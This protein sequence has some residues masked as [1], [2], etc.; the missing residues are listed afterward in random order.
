[1]SKKQ[2]EKP[3]NLPDTPFQME[4]ELDEDWALRFGYQWAGNEDD[5]ALQEIAK[6]FKKK[7]SNK[8][9]ELIRKHLQP[10]DLHWPTI[11]KKRKLS[12]EE[13]LLVIYTITNSGEDF[14]DLPTRVELVSHIFMGLQSTSLYPDLSGI[15]EWMSSQGYS[16]NMPPIPIPKR[17]IEA[18]VK[19]R[20]QD[21]QKMANKLATQL[22]KQEKRRVS[23][24]EVS[25]L[26]AGAKDCCINQ[27]TTIARIIRKEW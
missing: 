3:Q 12:P 6:S 4:G 27:H 18:T 20:N 5:P 7:L 15:I 25:I 2:K 10:N 16:M 21:I 19:E 9:L 8:Q 23:L 22:I 13:I 17:K 14:K 1:M 26:L 24:K 11:A